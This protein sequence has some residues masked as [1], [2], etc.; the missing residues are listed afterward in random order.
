MR[1]GCGQEHY[2]RRRFGVVAPASSR[3]AIW[4]VCA[5]PSF[6]PRAEGGNSFAG[7][8]PTPRTSNLGQSRLQLANGFGANKRDSAGSGGKNGL[9]KPHQKGVCEI[10]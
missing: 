9:R 5:P 8:K 3:N 1:V 7:R 10:R 2:L 6:A 4:A